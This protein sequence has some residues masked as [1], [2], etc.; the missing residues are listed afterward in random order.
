MQGKSK[1]TVAYNTD[2][3]TQSEMTMNEP[4][5]TTEQANAVYDILAANCGAAGDE[6]ARAAFVHHHAKGC[7]EYRCCGTFGFGGKFYLDNFCVDGYSEDMT[8]ER[9]RIRDAV[10]TKLAVLKLSWES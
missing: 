5:M 4:T 6:D 7:R 3:L 9:M 2:W 8:P 10:N 1:E